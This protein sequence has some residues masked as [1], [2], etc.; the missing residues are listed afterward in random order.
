MNRRILFMPAVIGAVALSIALAGCSAGGLP[1]GGTAAQG[2]NAAGGSSGS[3]SGGSGSGGCTASGTS[4]PA[5]HYSG[6]IKA[7][8]KTTMSLTVPGAGTLTGVG[9][10]LQG[11]NGTV[12]IVSNGSTVT[13]SIDLSGLGSSEIAG[14][15]AGSAGSGQFTGTISGSASNPQVSGTMSGDWDAYGPV[16]TSSGSASNAAHAGLH[17]TSAS[18]SAVSGDAIAM[19]AQIATPVKQYITITGTGAW[20]ATRH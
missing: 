3:G 8:L 4:I 19:F 2:T 13:G 18:C 14:G 10:G 16:T 5:G 7:T 17:V 1:G 9:N 20:T 11:M 12:D 15:A 6:T